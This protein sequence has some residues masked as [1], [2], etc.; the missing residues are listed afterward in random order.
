VPL[1]PYTLRAGQSVRV[2]SGLGA[3]RSGRLFLNRRISVWD[4]SRTGD[5]IQVRDGAGMVA[6]AIYYRRGHPAVVPAGGA[7]AVRLTPSGHAVGRF[8]R[9]FPALSTETD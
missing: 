2:Y 9:L 1:R 3:T 6:A 4:S 7:R 5:L 8:A